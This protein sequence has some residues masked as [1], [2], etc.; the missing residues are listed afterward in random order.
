M[1]EGEP[2]FL[3]AAFAFERQLQKNIDEDIQRCHEARNRILQTKFEYSP[4]FPFQPAQQQPQA[5]AGAPMTKAQ[6]SIHMVRRLFHTQ[7]PGYIPRQGQLSASCPESFSS[8]G[9]N[10]TPQTPAESS[11]WTRLKT[12]CRPT[13]EATKIRDTHI[14]SDIPDG[15]PS[16]TKYQ[17]HPYSNLEKGQ[18]SA[19][20]KSSSEAGSSG[21]KA[22]SRIFRSVAKVAVPGLVF[23]DEEDK[24]PPATPKKE[25]YVFGSDANKSPERPADCRGTLCDTWVYCGCPLMWSCKHMRHYCLPRALPVI[26]CRAPQAA[27]TESTEKKQNLFSKHIEWSHQNK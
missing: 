20:S 12:W 14:L 23:A 1:Y 4:T 13:W 8:T 18:Q 19:D 15:V 5:V 6:R 21:P 2:C 10:P 24:A 11:W 9:Y 25:S 27:P 22:C 7:L 26:A 16:L 3:A 17:A